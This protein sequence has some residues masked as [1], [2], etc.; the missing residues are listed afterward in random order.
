M[1]F[2]RHS[3]NQRKHLETLS[4]TPVMW[5]AIAIFV[6][7]VA[8]NWQNSQLMQ[9]EEEQLAASRLSRSLNLANMP[10]LT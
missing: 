9:W 2:Y 6:L 10:T 4:A 8:L 5:L 7:G 3:G 1:F